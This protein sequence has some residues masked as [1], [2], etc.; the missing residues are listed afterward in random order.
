[1]T[2]GETEFAPPQPVA[3]T[4]TAV[5]SAGDWLETS[6]LPQMGWQLP[7]LPDTATTDYGSGLGLL[8]QQFDLGLPP[9]PSAPNFGDSS[10]SDFDFS[11]LDQYLS[12]NRFPASSDSAT[13]NFDYDF[14]MGSDLGILSQY[15]TEIPSSQTNFL[16]PLPPLPMSSPIPIQDDAMPVETIATVSK[17]RKARDEVDPANV[18]HCARRRKA[19]KRA[20]EM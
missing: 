9:F 19:P 8:Q 14:L 18:V 16:P 10:S 20:D 1:M 4:S 3:L 2:L 6:P 5:S 11:F 13:G 15:S 12:V 17:K 7:A